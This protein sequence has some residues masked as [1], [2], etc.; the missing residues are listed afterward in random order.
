MGE[1]TRLIPESNS[2]REESGSYQRNGYFL[3]LLY[4]SLNLSLQNT[5]EDTM[6]KTI[7]TQ[8][9]IVNPKETF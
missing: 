2:G 1:T 7:M 4:K 3:I 8:H 6:K 9:L 5:F